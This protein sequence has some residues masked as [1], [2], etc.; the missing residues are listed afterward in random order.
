MNPKSKKGQIELQTIIFI[1]LL[2]GI[3]IFVGLSVL[4]EFESLD[5]FTDKSSNSNQVLYLTSSLVFTPGNEITSLNAQSYNQTWLEF[6]GNNDY[7]QVTS[8]DNASISFWYK[9]ATVGWQHIVNA[10]STS[11]VNGSSGTPLLYPIYYNG[12]DY[13]LGKS[14]STTF[15]DVD[16]DDFRIFNYILNSSDVSTLYSNG[17]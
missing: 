12:T 9:N 15:D 6:D 13:M 14:D 5:T 3:V 10:T 11:Y 7:L 16:I 2:V 8:T 17:R 1:V 4:E